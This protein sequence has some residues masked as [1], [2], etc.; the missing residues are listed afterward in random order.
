MAQVNP[1][2]TAQIIDVE[3]FPELGRKYK[4]GP[5]PRAIINERVDFVGAAPEDV[6]LEKVMSLNTP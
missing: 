1:R 5:I 2:V 6:V 4:V 3:R